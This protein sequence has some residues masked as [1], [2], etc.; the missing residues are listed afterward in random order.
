MLFAITPFV[1]RTGM[2]DKIKDAPEKV[3]QSEREQQDNN[4][5]NDIRLDIGNYCVWVN[6]HLVIVLLGLGVN[7]SE[8]NYL[9]QASVQEH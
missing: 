1:F 2:T 9:I 7:L 5:I 8:S 3:E 4:R 6:G